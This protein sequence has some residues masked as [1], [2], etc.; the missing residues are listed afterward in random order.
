MPGADQVKRVFIT[1]GA[2]SDEEDEGGQFFED[3]D[4]DDVDD[5]ED[6]D[7]Q[8]DDDAR[9]RQSDEVIDFMNERRHSGGGEGDED[10]HV[11]AGQQEQQKQQEQQEPVPEESVDTTA[12]GQA[13]DDKQD[14]QDEQYKQDNRLAGLA[15]VNADKLDLDAAQGVEN[16][17]GSARPPNAEPGAAN[18]N[19]TGQLYQAG[20]TTPLGVESESGNEDDEVEQQQPGNDGQEQQPGAVEPG[21]VEPGIMEPGVT[22]TEAGSNEDE[23][24]Q[25]RGGNGFVG[26]AKDLSASSSSSSSSEVGSDDE[27]V[28]ST[29]VLSKSSLYYVMSKVFMTEDG[30]NMA[31]LMS[32]VVKE[33]QN[34]NLRLTSME[35]KLGAGEATHHRAPSARASSKST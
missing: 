2:S 27:S 13:N 5:V 1:T 26:G 21:I 9:S 35:K 19:L 17:V 25:I 8:V 11:N 14:E 4:D 18:T 24:A 32:D 12:A 15:N 10:D 16:S 28:G 20:T 23:A 22:Q 6:V 7:D 3:Y 30:L 34:V 31:D 29:I 33:L